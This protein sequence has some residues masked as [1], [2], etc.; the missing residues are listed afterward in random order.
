MPSRKSRSLFS[1]ASRSPTTDPDIVHDAEFRFGRATVRR[2]RIQVGR[3][4]IVSPLNPS[5]KKHRGRP[6]VIGVA[7]RVV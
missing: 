1:D 5:A 4:Y 6:C 3:R 7:E 2:V